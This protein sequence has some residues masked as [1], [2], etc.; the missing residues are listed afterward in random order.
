[1]HDRRGGR[2]H[3]F[4]LHMSSIASMSIAWTDQTRANEDLGE[5]DLA[6]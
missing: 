4:A 5:V 1:L 6:R 2:V 3:P